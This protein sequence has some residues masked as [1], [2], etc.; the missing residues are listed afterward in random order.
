MI[1]KPGIWLAGSTAASQ[2][3]AMSENYWIWYV[4]YLVI[5]GGQAYSLIVQGY[6]RPPEFLAS[7]AYAG[8]I[9]KFGRVP[10]EVNIMPPLQQK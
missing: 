2:L 8:N 7:N 6:I 3:E 1:F 9:A 5:S 10:H 4:F